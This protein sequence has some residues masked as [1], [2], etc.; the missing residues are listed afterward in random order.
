[1]DREGVG[2]R[3]FNVGEHVKRVLGVIIGVAGV[4]DSQRGLRVSSGTTGGSS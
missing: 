1:V 3:E 2:E 4:G